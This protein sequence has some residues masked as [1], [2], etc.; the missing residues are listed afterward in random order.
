MSNIG[1]VGNDQFRTVQTMPGDYMIW[2]RL[3]DANSPALLIVDGASFRL[4]NRSV[5]GQVG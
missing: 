1:S 4:F 2:V 5:P 3:V